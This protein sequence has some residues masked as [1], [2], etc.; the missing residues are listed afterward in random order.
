MKTLQLDKD[1]LIDKLSKIEYLKSSIEN[2]LKETNSKIENLKI[3]EKNIKNDIEIRE[4]SIMREISDTKVELQKLLDN[5]I[6]EIQKILEEK[7]RAF[8][9]L[10]DA[11][12]QYYY[13]YIDFKVEEHLR[14][15]LHPAKSSADK[16][17]EIANEKRELN[18]KFLI[19]RNLLK[20]YEA[21]F[22]WLADYV[23]ENIDDLLIEAFNKKPVDENVDPV[24]S[25]M[26]PAEYERLT[27]SERNQKALDRYWKSRKTTWEVGRDYER[28]IGYLYE[29]QGYSV[30]YLGIEKGLE[31]LGRDLICKKNNE[32][33][34]IQCKYWRQ[35]KVI[36]EKHINQLFGTTVEYFIKNCSSKQYS[37]LN[38]FPKLLLENSIRAMVITSASVSET[39]KSFAKA[40][41]II[42]KEKFPF[43]QGYPSIKCNVSF[44]DGAKIYHLP[45]DQ[46]YDR[47]RIDEERNECYVA[48]VKEAEKLGFRRAWKWYG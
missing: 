26:T 33:L 2:L 10:S 30:Q 31:D 17:K 8:P 5:T 42:I 38:L 11:I 34:V 36:H 7:T 9:W 21:L 45:F 3:L 20:Y 43:N 40:L 39:A 48:T 46:Q 47:T 19:T 24:Y 27:A 32:V 22:P 4:V 37:E 1:L 16:V 35:E 18:K 23:G 12:A 44:R 41:G 28:Y 29:M 14:D 6:H 25:F 13:D 15:K